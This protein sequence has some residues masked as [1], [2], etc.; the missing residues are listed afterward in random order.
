MGL[1]E[2]DVGAAFYV[3]EWVIRL[4]ALFTVPFRRSPA[5]TRAWLLL[6]F[7][8][9]VP[10]LL[11]FWTIGSPRFPE[12]RRDRFRELDTWFTVIG[13]RLAAVAPPADAGRDPIIGLSRSLGQMPATTGNDIT[14]ISDYDAAIEQLVTDIDD[15]RIHVRILVYIFA[16]DAV[17]WR[18]ADALARA[19]AR[20]VTCHV[21]FDPVGSRPWRKGL[22]PMLER[23]G[24]E[25]QQALPLRWLRGRTRRDMRNHR[26]LFVIDGMIGYVGSQNIVAQDFKPGIVNRELVA[27][28]TGPVVVE[29]EAL[30]R[31]DWYMET[32]ALP[33]VP[34][35]IP[36]RTGEGI[37]QLLPSGANHPLEGFKTLLVWQLHRAESHGVLVTP[38]FIP[39]D[40]L[41]DAM[42]TAALRGV[43]IDI[44]LSSVVDQWLVHSAQS[45]YYTELM[46]AGVHIHSY[47]DYLL[48]AKTV[49]IDGQLA[50]VGS[51]NVDMRSFQ[52]NEEAS[53]L[54]LDAASVAAVE[55]VQ[56]DYLAAS[57]ELDLA[58]W[59]A[60]PFT[61][62]VAEN[63]ARMVG[64]LL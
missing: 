64:S 63:V 11:L 8:L 61:R 24:V 57:D 18:V 35:M 23:A 21:M 41:L 42:R 44:V 60:R 17:G 47:R 10:G 30:V 38:Y 49:S 12:W 34:L 39:D 29:M 13:Q 16:D 2:S 58:T 53:L 37:A 4:G 19:V 22:R 52:L 6:I 28:V 50:V 1:P 40:D 7:F 26:K 45:S 3:L 15:A 27:R 36:D 31:A 25:V 14:L 48:H 62:K 56:R 43:R 9:P 54:L 20:G 33:D 59:R 32:R 5:A 46:A 55:A 51:S